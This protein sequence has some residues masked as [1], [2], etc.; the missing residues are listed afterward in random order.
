MGTARRVSEDRP[1]ISPDGGR[2]Q[3]TVEAGELGVAGENGGD[4]DRSC[5]QGQ[6]E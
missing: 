3:E 1:A 6:E 5:S 4:V 2:G